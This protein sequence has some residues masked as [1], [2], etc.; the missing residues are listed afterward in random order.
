MG[1]SE[2]QTDEWPLLSGAASNPSSSRRI[3]LTG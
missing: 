2:P 3:S 1:P